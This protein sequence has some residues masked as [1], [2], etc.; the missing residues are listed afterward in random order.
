[1][2]PF[3]KLVR[4]LISETAVPKMVRI[5]YFVGNRFDNADLLLKSFQS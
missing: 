2:F 3:R 5:Q 4:H 1:M